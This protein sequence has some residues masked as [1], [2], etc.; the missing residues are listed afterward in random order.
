MNSEAQNIAILLFGLGISLLSLL[1]FPKLIKPILADL[2]IPRI[3]F[4]VAL[5]GL[6]TALFLNQ[7]KNTSLLYEINFWLQFVLIILALIYAAVFAIIINNFADLPTDKISNPDRPLVVESVKKRPYFIAGI[8]SQ[9]IALL[10]SFLTKPEIFIGILCI[11]IGYFI[12]SA[13]PF[14]LKKVVGLAKLIIGFNSLS[15]AVMGFAAAGGNWLDF[16]WE[17]ALFILIPLSLAANFIDLKDI[18]GDRAMGVK[19]IPVL[20]GE[21]NARHFMAISAL[22]CYLT[23]GF[24]LS[25]SWVWP[26]NLIT[27][28]C[29]LYF[30]Y[31]KP[32]SEKFIF[33]IF[34][35][36]LFGLDVF[37]FFT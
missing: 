28:T 5:S 14:R 2:R 27:A 24:L 34:V 15:V 1:L 30:L 29:H 25:V 18:E 17:W 21:K 7:A 35:S 13:P 16:P 37:L 8:I 6:G 33:L 3:L 12:Y 22:I 31:R 4:Y 36:A 19:T 23:G 20:I 11:S 9:I 10:V 26:L 32:F